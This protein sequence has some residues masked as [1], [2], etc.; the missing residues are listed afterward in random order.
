MTFRRAGVAM[1]LAATL[2]WVA[3]AQTVGQNDKEFQ[4]ALQKEMVAG[5]LEGAIEEY[6]RIVERPGVERALAAEALLRMA[7]CFEKLRDGQARRVY[8]RIITSFSEQKQTAD[9]AR[10]R[11]AALGDL[12]PAAA[13]TPQLVWRSNAGCGIRGMACV[14]EPNFEINDVSADGRL[15]IGTDL[16]SDPADLAIRDAVTGQFVRL[17]VANT[18]RNLRAGGWPVLSP[19]GQQVAYLWDASVPGER[20]KAQL[21][22]IARAPGAQARILIDNPEFIYLIPNA[23]SPDGRILVALERPDS[24][25]QLAWI[26]VADR[27]LTVL[28]SLDWRMSGNARHVSLSPDGRHV[29]YCA[30]AINPKGPGRPDSTDTRVYVIAADGSAETTLTTT[31]GGN[32]SPTWTADGKHILFVSDYLG[33][34]SLWSVAMQDGKAVSNRALVRSNIGDAFTIG[35]TRSGGYHYRTRS[36]LNTISI[37]DAGFP[38]SRLRQ[39]RLAASWEGIQAGRPTGSSWR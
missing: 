39:R 20:R 15:L 12:T 10:T 3:A 37:D 8:Q 30:L 9:S 33:S 38:E 14:A 16:S 7:G 4:A 1:V 5:D 21:R 2:V 27:S 25:W 22:V 34:P 35:M 17:G 29:A 26:T 11:L 36:Y 13:A 32:C 31:A 18:P 19:D 28:K 24:T 6:R 23:W